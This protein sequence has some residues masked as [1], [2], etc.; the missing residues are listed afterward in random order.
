[1]TI[2]ICFHLPICWWSVLAEQWRSKMVRRNRARSEEGSCTSA[3]HCDSCASALASYERAH[4]GTSLF[5]KTFFFF[6]V[7]FFLLLLSS[8]LSWIGSH[9]G[10]RCV[11]H[12]RAGARHCSD[13]H[14]HFALV[15][16]LVPKR[17]TSTAT[18]MYRVWCF[19]SFFFFPLLLGQLVFRPRSIFQ[20]ARIRCLSIPLLSTEQ[21]S[22]EQR[23]EKR[24][25][26][27]LALFPLSSSS[28]F[29][30]F[31]V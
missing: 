6:P 1:M 19:L 25:N 23:K 9:K 21:P 31:C 16:H 30:F 24:E 10:K 12:C 7:T 2:L 8:T 20:A 13:R 5:L 18:F 17:I 28:P 14:I 11:V 29:N 15:A 26:F 22:V 4:L 3:T 27:S